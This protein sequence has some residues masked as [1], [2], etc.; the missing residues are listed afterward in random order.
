VGGE[1][2]KKGCAKPKIG[3][4]SKRKPF[5]EGAGKR[6]GKKGWGKDLGKEGL[7]KNRRKKKNHGVKGGKKYNP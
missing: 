2:R 7:R 6:G 3:P 4:W 1:T 5:L